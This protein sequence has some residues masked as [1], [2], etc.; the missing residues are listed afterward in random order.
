MIWRLRYCSGTARAAK[1][2]YFPTLRQTLKTRNA[3]RPSVLL[4]P[5]YGL[6]TAARSS[7]VRSSC[8]STSLRAGLRDDA[9]CRPTVER[10]RR[11]R[12]SIRRG[13]RTCPAWRRRLNRRRQS[14]P[15]RRLSRATLHSR[16]YRRALAQCAAIGPSSWPECIEAG[17]SVRGRT[18]GIDSH[19]QNKPAAP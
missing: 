12:P 16:C 19:F 15:C 6:R 7:A 14:A 4:Q 5:N 10:I 11:S 1:C 8:R 18:A 13:E 2:K 17:A 3:T 9:A